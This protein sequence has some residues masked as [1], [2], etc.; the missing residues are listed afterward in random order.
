MANGSLSTFVEL[1]FRRTYL[2]MRTAAIP[3]R[4]ACL[5]EKPCRDPVHSEQ[6]F[7]SYYDDTSRPTYF[8]YD[9][10]RGV[11]DELA[12]ALIFA[13]IDSRPAAHI[14]NE[15]KTPVTWS[16]PKPHKRRVTH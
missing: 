16:L 6:G 10:R 9:A 7:S 4:A 2:I 13:W 5:N 14:R 1:P 3:S 12:A 11:A 15:W 8:K